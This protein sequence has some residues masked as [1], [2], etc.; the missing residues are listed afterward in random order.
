MTT[1]SARVIRCFDVY[2]EC[3]ALAAQPPANAATRLL[4]LSN[5][6]AMLSAR[7]TDDYYRLV[8]QLRVLVHLE[9]Q[10]TDWT[11]PRT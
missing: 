8:R 3:G 9:S 7:E 6:L 10:V 1:P 5:D 4:R 11:K 2:R